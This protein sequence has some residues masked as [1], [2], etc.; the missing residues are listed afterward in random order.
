MPR[1]TFA[2]EMELHLEGSPGLVAALALAVQREARYKR[3]GPAC[4]PVRGGHAG[5]SSLVGPG[6]RLLRYKSGSTVFL[7]YLSRPGCG[8]VSFRRALGA[9]LDLVHALV[10]AILFHHDLHQLFL[11]V[12]ITFYAFSS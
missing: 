6:G 10:R 5:Y 8:C 9:V 11:G 4:S 7:P 2:C 1:V 3:G 12:D